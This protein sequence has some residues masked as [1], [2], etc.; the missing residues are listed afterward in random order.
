[1]VEETAG[2]HI[3]FLPSNLKKLGAHMARHRRQQGWISIDRGQYVGHWDV[4]I[5]Q[6]GKEIRRNRQIILGK[7]SRKYPEWRAREELE[8]LIREDP[9]VVVARPDPRTTLD[10]FYTN[11]FKPLAEGRWRDSTRSS[12]PYVIEKHILSQFGGLALSRITR[13][14]IQTWLDSLCRSLSRWYVQKIRN[15]FHTIMEEAIDQEYV[16]RNP[17][18]KTRIHKEKDASDRYLTLDEIASLE[19]LEGRERLVFHMMTLLGLRPG[20]LF[21]RRWRDWQ[22]D[23]LSIADDVWRGTIDQTKTETSRAFVSL[24]QLLRRELETYRRLSHWTDP[25]DFIFCSRRGIPLDAHNYLRRVFKQSCKQ[26]GVEDV[27]F[28]CFR[29]TCSTYMVKYSGGSI[30]DA[31]AHLR[32]ANATTTL[33]IYT[34]AIPDSVR[35]AVEELSLRLFPQ[36]NQPDPGE[37]ANARLN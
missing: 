7:V 12:Q 24:P 23:R 18:A 10:W 8:R 31:Q 29:R 6:E 14:D 5:K 36:E 4:Y 11:R 19:K 15:L 27:T 33:Q 20:E 21:A 37:T 32:H 28:Q 17:V 30:K 16:E 35:A 3:E 2:E 26:L 22:E 9:C 13:F 1:M 25:E 34:K